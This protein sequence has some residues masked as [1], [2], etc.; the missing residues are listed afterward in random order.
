MNT[1]LLLV[2]GMTCD[3]CV[4]S[5]TEELTELDGVSDVRVR[6]VPGGASEVTVTSDAP[7]ASDALRAA[8]TEAGYEV[9]RS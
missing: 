4:M 6:L 5:V 3:H 1:E 9:V 8:V 2:E 7:V